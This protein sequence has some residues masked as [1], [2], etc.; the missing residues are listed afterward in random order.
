MPEIA[1][2][3]KAIKP[4]TAEHPIGSGK[5]VTYQPGDEVPAGD[6]GRAADNLVENGKIMRYAVN[7]YAPGE[8]G[9]ESPPSSGSATAVA[10]DAGGAPDDPGDEPTIDPGADDPDDDA[11]PGTPGA[12]PVHRGRGNYVLSDGSRVRGREEAEAAQAALD[13]AV[14]A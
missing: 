4:I 13:A 7:V 5:I 3:F 9:G 10:V 12:F 8:T 11:D 6:W 1:F 2:G 14:E